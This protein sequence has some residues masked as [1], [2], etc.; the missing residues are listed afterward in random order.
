MQKTGVNSLRIWV[1][2]Y[3]ALKFKA[4]RLCLIKTRIAGAG[5]SVASGYDIVFPLQCDDLMKQSVG[6]RS[7]TN[8]PLKG[9][10]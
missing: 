10:G 4:L 5:I 9:C 3:L 8:E 7:L 6:V 2:C 1:E